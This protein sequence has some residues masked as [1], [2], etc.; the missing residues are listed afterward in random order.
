MPL[1]A[2]PEAEW[3]HGDS[4]SRRVDLLAAA[5]A[6]PQ[7]PSGILDALGAAPPRPAAARP[8]AVP[9]AAAR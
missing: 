8:R 5:P 6:G 7:P 4:L 1:P 9:Q 3:A 2:T